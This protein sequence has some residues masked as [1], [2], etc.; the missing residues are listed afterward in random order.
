MSTTIHSQANY[1]NKPR[2]ITH[3]H[4][5]LFNFNSLSTNLVRLLAISAAM[6]PMSA[7]PQNNQALIVIKHDPP[8]E[9][10]H[11][12]ARQA[13]LLGFKEVAASET[14]TKGLTRGWIMEVEEGLHFDPSP[15]KEEPK[16]SWCT[17]L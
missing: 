13:N 4:Q 12:R 7:A 14:S 15:V 11:I 5:S 16:G 3:R 8:P 1:L 2:E 17:I 10:H 9:H 6:K